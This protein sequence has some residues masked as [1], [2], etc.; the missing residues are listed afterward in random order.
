VTQSQYGFSTRH[1]ENPTGGGNE[2]A[3]SPHVLFKYE[4]LLSV[5]R[6]EGLSGRLVDVGCGSGTFQAYLRSHGWS[7]T[8]GVEPSG[9]SAGRDRL[10]LSI[11]NEPVEIFA[12]R[13]QMRESFDVAVANHVL[14]HTYDPPQFLR[15]LGALLVPGGH[16]LLATPNID[17]AAMRF[18]TLV[19]RIT[20]KRRPFRHLDY[21]KHL[22]LFNRANLQRLARDA[23]FVALR[24]ETYTRASRDSSRRQSRADL[25]DR[26]GFGDNM[27]LLGRRPNPKG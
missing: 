1:E 2:L 10:G 23:G 7:E 9:N 13:P 17:G 27:F 8:V 25:W 24:C 22:V 14:E 6:E 5:L 26:L 12:E 11:W 4:V 16:A 3:G 15:N 19:S 21:P 18:K 20:R